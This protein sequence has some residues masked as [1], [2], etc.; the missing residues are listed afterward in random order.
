MEQIFYS[1][2]KTKFGWMGITANDY[3]LMSIILP[4]IDEDKV[5]SLIKKRVAQENL[6]RKEK[7][8]KEIKD[9]LMKYFEGKK[10]TFDYL[11]DLRFATGFEKKVF[12]AT[13]SIPY[14]ERRSYQ[15]LAQE[16]GSP[17]ASRA[18]GQALKKNPLPI[19]IPCHR[20]I[21]RN[22]KLGGFL[23][24]VEF[25]QRLLLLEQKFTRFSGSRTIEETYKTRNND[26]HL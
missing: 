8:F 26:N 14:G 21:Y 2:F 25:K 9:L 7:Y 19:I 18:V 10:V 12:E 15:F 13:R 5:F 24:G 23:A 16:V 20:V 1:R 11:L 22:G 17:K 6:I 3:G 4:Q